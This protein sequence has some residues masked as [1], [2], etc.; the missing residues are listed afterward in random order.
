MDP[1]TWMEYLQSPKV[2]WRSFRRRLRQTN[3]RVQGFFQCVELHLLLLLL[4]LFR[5]IHRNQLILRELCFRLPLSLINVCHWSSSFHHHHLV[6]C[7]WTRIPHLDWSQR[8]DETIS[9]N[10]WLNPEFKYFPNRLLSRDLQR[11][12]LYPQGQRRGD[13]MYA[14]WGRDRESDA[15]IWLHAPTRI[16]LLWI[17]SAHLVPWQQ[18]AEAHGLVWSNSRHTRAIV[19]S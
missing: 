14:D 9:V 7:E 16:I 5:T 4:L 15:I 6:Y 11:S 19:G 8:R 3:L 18:P 1:N 10:P 17:S 2:E 13:A 12:D